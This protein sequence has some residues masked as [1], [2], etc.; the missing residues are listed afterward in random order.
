MILEVSNLP[1]WIIKGAFGWLSE[2]AIPKANAA[3]GY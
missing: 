2:V 3:P 1:R